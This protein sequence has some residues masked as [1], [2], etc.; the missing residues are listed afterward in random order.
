MLQLGLTTAV[1]VLG[2]AAPPEAVLPASL[3]I[4]PIRALAVQHDGRWP[5]LD[6]VARDVV[7]SVTGE[8]SPG[9]HDPVLLLLAWIFDP[10]TWQRQPLIS[11]R[12]AELRAELELPAEQTAFSYAELVGHAPL[13][14]IVSRVAQRSA[15][16]KLNPLEAEA[17][18]I[19]RRLITLLEVFSGRTIKAIPDPQN[20]DGAWRPIVTGAR[21]SAGDTDA[22]TAA[23]A[24]LDEAFSSDDAPAFAEASRRLITA[25]AEL[26]AAYR[27]AP[28]RIATELRYNRHRPFR[29]AWLA[30]AAGVVI[31]LAALLLRAPQ[32]ASV[33]AFVGMALG[34]AALSYGLWLRWQIADRIPAANMFESLLFLGWGAGAFAIVSLIFLRD[35]FVPL[36]ASVM[37]AAALILADQLPLDRFVRPIV[38]V[39]RDT[40]WMSI[41]VPVIMSSYAVLAVAVLIAHVQ[42][43]LMALLPTRR[44]LARRID[45]LHYWYALIGSFLLL[46][47]IITGSMWGASSWGR[48]WGWDP[49]EVWSL[50]AFLGYMA[51]LH[52]RVNH[53]RTPPWA[54]AVAALLG[55][56]V[57]IA[58]V[59]HMLPFTSTKVYALAAAGVAG[60]IFVLARGPFATALK[61]ILAFWLIIMTYVGVNYVLGT[62]LH[63]YGFGTGAVARHMFIVGYV[64]LGLIGLCA[65]VYQMRT[66]PDSHAPASTG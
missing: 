49:K 29:A 15:D 18:E 16:V 20:P 60:I 27:P 8:Q 10:G 55:S 47:G 63:S 41:H 5:P 31:A 62:G 54:Y 53:E 7:E 2:A 52:V 11:I 57:A 43:L 59:P 36:T 1:L 37:G 33:V 56:G 23:W 65:A 24:A 26:P 32:V 13:R 58:V 64:D 50:V 21:H 34:F 61:S 9:G 17:G 6:T 19:Q 42:L 38:P 28:E 22:V 14:R 30:M 44:D 39:L 66:L 48:Y 4:E 35:R 46:A 51:I 25:L 45:G 3:D 12:N 40:I